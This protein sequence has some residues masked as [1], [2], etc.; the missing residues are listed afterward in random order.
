MSGYLGT[1]LIVSRDDL[2]CSQLSNALVEHALCV[3]F[4]VGALTAMDRLNR[5]KFE[6]VVVD[7]L[8]GDQ[9]SVCLQQIRASASNST[10]VTFALTK[11]AEENAQAL[12]G[13]FSFGLNRPL[14]ADSISHTVRVA[15]GLIVRERRR[16][17]RY[18]VGI[19]VVLNRKEAPIVYGRTVNISERGM[20]LS[21]STPLAA[22]DEG[23]IE[24]T[25]PGTVLHIRAESRVCWNDG[26]GKSGLSFLSVPFHM[27]SQLQAWLAR[28]LEEQMPEAVVDRFRLPADLTAVE[29]V[30]MA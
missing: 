21:T 16:Y 9:T 4:C 24:F 28:K 11:S 12:K 27:A 10:A 13:G 15:Y 18:P 25:L 2:A 30:Q 29:E 22:G 8:L 7:S 1:V 17:F 23:T 20:A 14:T 6:A 26:R 3:E 5:R 19:P